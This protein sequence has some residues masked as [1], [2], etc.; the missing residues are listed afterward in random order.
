MIKTHI[1]QEGINWQRAITIDDLRKKLTSLKKKGV[2][3]LYKEDGFNNIEARID[4]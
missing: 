1:I 2:E 4:K 3:Y